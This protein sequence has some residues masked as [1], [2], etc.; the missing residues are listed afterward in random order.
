M[1]VKTV[2][3]VKFSNRGLVMA[4]R[5]GLRMKAFNANEPACADGNRCTDDLGLNRKQSP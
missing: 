4:A 2:V 3:P 1:S 5:M